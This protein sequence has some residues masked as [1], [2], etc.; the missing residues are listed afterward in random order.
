MATTF[1]LELNNKPNKRGAYAIYLRITQNRKLKR[2]KT[3]VE[4]KRASDFNKSTKNEKWIRPSEPNHAI[5]NE[6]LRIEV[7]KAK[8]T[9]REL[10]NDGLA[11]S[12]KIVSEIKAGEQTLSFLEYAKVRTQEILDA[13]GFRKCDKK[14]TKA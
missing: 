1:A 12:D 8:Q 4:V 6:A 10:K 14:S 9:Y 2:I 3:S 5:W 7:E 11:T 13:G